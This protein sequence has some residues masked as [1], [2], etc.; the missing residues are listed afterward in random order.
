MPKH[1]RRFLETYRGSSF[2]T[3]AEMSDGTVGVVKM[4]GAGNGAEALVS[5]FVVN[6]LARAAGLAVPDAFV[7]EI[8][9]GFPWDFGTDEFHDLVR[10]SPG[11][12]LGLEWIKGA[13]PVPAADYNA[14]PHAFVAQVVSLDLTFANWDRTVRSGNLLV[15]RR[16]QPWIVDHGSCRF[17]FQASRAEPYRLPADHVFAGWEAAFEPGWL[18]RVSPDLVAATVAEIPEAWL[19][20]AGLSREGVKT[21]LQTLASKRQNFEG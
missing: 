8:A 5:E 3:R 16:G 7:V 6:R 20:E 14:L 10:K 19:V 18:G 13:R 2:P 17:L 1:L 11:P 15:D 4:R 21:K 12:N 9:A